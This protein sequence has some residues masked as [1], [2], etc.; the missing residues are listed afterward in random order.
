VGGRGAVGR[1]AAIPPQ[2][3]LLGVELADLGPG[4]PAADAEIPPPASSAGTRPGDAREPAAYG[5]RVVRV[6]TD[7][8]AEQAGIK[9]DDVIA[10]VNEKPIDSREA[11]VATIRSYMPGQEVRLAVRRGGETVELKASWPAGI[12]PGSRA[13]MMNKM[14]GPLSLRRA[15]FP[16]VLQHDT[17]LTPRPSAARW[18]RST[19]RRRDQHRPGRPGRELRPPGRRDRPAAGRPQ[20]R[21]ARPQAAGAPTTTPGRRRTRT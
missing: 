21:Q 16:A 2:N 14:G 6:F 10:R 19:G 7:S 18:S 9:V 20:E 12:G 8:P 5:A 15:N 1:A 17:V 11:L 4:S 13:E 3:G